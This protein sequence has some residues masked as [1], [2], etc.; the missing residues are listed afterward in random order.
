MQMW[1]ILIQK[2]C[3][4]LLMSWCKVTN[5][6][7]VCSGSPPSFMSDW[8]GFKDLDKWLAPRPAGKGGKQN[9]DM[10]SPSYFL[11]RDVNKEIAPCRRRNQNQDG[12]QR[13]GALYLADVVDEVVVGC[14]LQL[15]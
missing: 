7:R 5:K 9:E 3:G 4:I 14:K 15:N 2:V 13:V 12:L 10:P 11:G 1:L 8:G 6:E